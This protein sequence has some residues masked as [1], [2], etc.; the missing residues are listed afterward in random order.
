MNTQ[1]SSATIERLDYLSKNTLCVTIRMI[2]GFTFTPGQYIT[3]TLPELS[4]ESSRENVRDFSICSSPITLPLISIAF[5]MSESKFKQHIANRKKGDEVHVAG[6]KGV[7]VL[8]AHGPVSIIAGGIGIT[9]FMSMLQTRGQ[10]EGHPS[11]SIYYFHREKSHAVFSDELRS[12]QDII[13]IHEVSDKY[14]IGHISPAELREKDRTWY[15]AG[16][17]DMVHAVLTSLTQHGVQVNRIMTED[18]VGYA[19]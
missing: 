14:T 12:M 16:P 1:P 3:L 11:S 9:P 4:A 7:F 6:P 17:P 10:L 5:R 19:K 2:D 8:A 15:V 13:S 18:F